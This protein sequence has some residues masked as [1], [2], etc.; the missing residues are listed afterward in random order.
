MQLWACLLFPSLPL[1]VF[2]RAQ[3]SEDAQRPFVVGSG[4][5]YPRVVAAN[6]AAREAG[7]RNDQLISA[8]L[9]LAPDL[10]MRDRDA[11]AES[12]ALAQLATWT[13]TFTPMA[14][15]APPNAI[16]AEIGASLRLFGGLPRL[17]ARLAGGAHAL[18]YANRLGIAPTPVAAL[19][20][21]RAGITQPVDHP[22]RLPCV[23]DPLPLTLLDLPDAARDTLRAAGVTTFA[24]A[25]KLPRDGLARRFGHEIVLRLDRVLGLVPDP[26]AAFVPPPVFGAR[27]D[28][29]APVHDADALVFGLSRLVRDLADWLH[30]RGLGAVRLTLCL[31]HE[32][33]LRKRGLPATEVPFAL[34]APTR[35]PSHLMGVLRE[36]LTRVTLPAPVEGMSLR[37]DETA[38]LAGRNLGLLPGDDADR[39]EV[40][41]A[42]R[43][44]ARLGEDALIRLAPHADHRP[45]LATQLEAPSAKPP[46][47]LPDAPR[48]LWLLSE[49]Q[50][51]ASVMES[52]PWVLRDGPERIESGWW[53]GADIRRDYYVADTHDGATVWIYRD[54]RYGV[55]DGEWFLHGLFA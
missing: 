11:A 27:L 18:G 43:L 2:A 7:I 42:D 4:G 22:A 55:E 53:D 34:G 6:R 45:E 52:R 49:P 10:A 3:S 30:A 14:C 28:L 51:L 33:Y 24:Q 54:H 21:A 39:V 20:L 26:R 40:P 31:E 19:L 38:P 41:L 25:A 35:L 8:A 44:R 9:A 5:H 23:L 13:L 12:A 15:L 48:P 1:D 36:R 37:S 16:V 29:P 47:A 32:R 50:P 46:V 17:V